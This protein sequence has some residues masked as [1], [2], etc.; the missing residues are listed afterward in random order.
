MI[1]TEVR[2]ISSKP[3]RYRG[4]LSGP[5]EIN[6]LQSAALPNRRAVIEAFTRIASTIY[7][8][9]TR[10]SRHAAPICARR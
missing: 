4:K 6:N 2:E 7:T 9:S 10:T 5:L 8:D 3:G 1:K